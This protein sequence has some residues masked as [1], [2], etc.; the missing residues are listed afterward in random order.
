MSTAEATWTWQ[1]TTWVP[2][3][4]T[5]TTLAGSPT[6]LNQVAAVASTAAA[7]ALVCGLGL[8]QHLGGSVLG[9]TFISKGP[10]PLDVSGSQFAQVPW[11]FSEYELVGSLARIRLLADEH[12]D[13]RELLGLL[14]PAIRQVFG[15]EH[16]S[17]ISL[18]WVADQEEDWS[19]LVITIKPSAPT[20][21]QRITLEDRLLKQIAENARMRRALKHVVINHP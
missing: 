20:W 18:E 3:D 5:A 4:W 9:K 8:Y 7:F 19:Q 1:G 11:P 15:L 10:S 6:S 16:A 13:V 14:V 21:E 17:G 12:P 2:E